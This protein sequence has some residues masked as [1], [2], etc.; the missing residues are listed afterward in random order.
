MN[1]PAP[2]T[3]TS[4]ANIDLDWVLCYYMNF[5]SKHDRNEEIELRRSFHTIVCRRPMGNVVEENATLSQSECVEAVLEFGEEA[6]H[7]EEEI[8][9]IFEDLVTSKKE[10]ENSLPHRSS[11]RRQSIVQVALPYF[12]HPDMSYCI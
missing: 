12:S 11:T 10:P 6:L 1:A 4:Y 9:S 5:W 2:E 3:S 8:S 7:D